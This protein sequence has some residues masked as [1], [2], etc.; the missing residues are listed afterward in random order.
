MKTRNKP[1][2]EYQII[3]FQTVNNRKKTLRLHRIVMMAFR[4]VDNM[5]ELEVNHIDGD[6]TNNKLS[7]LEWCTPSENQKH[8]FALGLQKARRGKA[9]NFAKLTEE[10]VK[11]I[12]ELRK[13]GMLQR[14]I[15]DLMECTPSNI[16][17]ILNH[18]SW[19]V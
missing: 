12:F 7:N 9:S 10:D 19:K 4:P 8:A 5:D 15:A 2:T 17:Y 13:Q 6:K 18:K 3:N 16:S 1:G 14:E 11:K